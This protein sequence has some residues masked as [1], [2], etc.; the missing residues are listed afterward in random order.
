VALASAFTALVT[1]KLANQAIAMTGELSLDGTVIAV[2][3]IG[4]KV[5]SLAEVEDI[6]VLCV[7]RENLDDAVWAAQ[8]LERPLDIQAINSIWDVIRL[9]HKDGAG[10]IEPDTGCPGR[11][12]S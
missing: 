7:P 2:G 6:R 9:A 10:E 5:K 12:A 3:G 8:R 11:V 4:G 1:G